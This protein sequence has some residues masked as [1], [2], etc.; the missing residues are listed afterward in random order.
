MACDVTDVGCQISAVAAPIVIPIVLIVVL[1]FIGLFGGKTGKLIA[2][3]GI[4]VWF[5]WYIGLEW[6]GIPLPP[7]RTLFSIGTVMVHAV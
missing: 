3:V 2:L 1:L 6:A 5:L 7:F 4:V